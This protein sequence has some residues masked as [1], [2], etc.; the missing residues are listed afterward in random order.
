MG[1]NLAQLLSWLAELP[2]SEVAALHPQHTQASVRAL[3]PRLKYFDKGTCF[4]HHIFEGEVHAL[5]PH[6]KD[7]DK[8]CG[9]NRTWVLGF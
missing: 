6:L 7:F 5:L 9:S 2:D 1:R 8:G 4:V 3:L